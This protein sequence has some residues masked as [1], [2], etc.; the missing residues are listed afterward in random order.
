MGA[1]SGY[2]TTKKFVFYEQ[3][4]DISIDLKVHGLT[5]AITD[6]LNIGNFMEYTSYEVIIVRSA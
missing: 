4:E 2:L 1:N 6:L 5:T 3:R